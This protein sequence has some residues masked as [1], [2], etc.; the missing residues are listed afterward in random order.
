MIIKIKEPKGLTRHTSCEWKCKF[1]GRKC[2]SDQWWANDKCRCECK[3]RHVCEKDHTWIPTTC[4]C[5][6]GKYLASIIDDSGIMRDENMESYN[7]ET[8]TIATKFNEK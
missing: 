7:E 2:N 3:K 5:E 8:K 1:D 4:S 6:Y